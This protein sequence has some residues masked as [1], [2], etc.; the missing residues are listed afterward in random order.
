MGLGV[1]AVGFDLDGTLFD[2]RCAADSAVR[3][4]LD[5]RG[6]VTPGA[7]S[8]TDEWLR[9]ENDIFARYVRGDVSFQQ[10]RRDRVT[11]FLT[12]LDVDAAE[13]N[14]D[15]LFDQ[16]LAFYESAWVAY[17]DA[18]SVLD[19]VQRMGLRVGVLTNGSKPQQE[20]KL[21]AI[22]LH[23]RF[24]VVLASSELPAGKP[25]PRAFHAFC[26]A[27]N[28]NPPRVL[29]AGDDLHSDVHGAHRAGLRAVWVNR[30][31]TTGS[32]DAPVIDSLNEI[33][34]LLN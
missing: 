23:D 11:G 7:S 17:P 13:F 29:F 3:H 1:M 21:R 33:V 9:L 27:L 26:E 20:A 6:W 22:G 31:E 5:D 25:D 2:H 34:A 24:D 8:P 14:L 19:E 16:Y 28:T 4:W 18:L 10:Q 15:G 30:G 32:T 12:W